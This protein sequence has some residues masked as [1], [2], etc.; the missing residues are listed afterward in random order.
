MARIHTFTLF[1]SLLLIGFSCKKGSDPVTPELNETLKAMRFLLA[2]KSDLP[3]QYFVSG[4]FNEVKVNCAT[5]NSKDF[6]YHDTTYNYITHN[7]AINLDQIGITR[8]NQE[9]TIM[10]NIFFLQSYLFSRQLPYTLPHQNP[11]IGE[12]AEVQLI[13]LKNYHTPPEGFTKEDFKFSGTSG[14]NLTIQVINI[15][16]STLQG[17]FHGVLTNKRGID[18]TVRDGSFNIKL[19]AI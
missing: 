16:D 3:S 9:S 13:D 5:T 17:K 18:I 8:E 4:V 19:K 7:A 12:Y 11:R 2:A 10:V 6:P 15:N 1:C 14:T